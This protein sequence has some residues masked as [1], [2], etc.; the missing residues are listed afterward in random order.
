MS[1]S[2]SPLI[3]GDAKEWRDFPVEDFNEA[4]P[5]EDPLGELLAERTPENPFG[6]CIVANPIERIPDALVMRMSGTNIPT[7]IRR[8]SRDEQKPAKKKGKK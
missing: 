2:E 7:K 3:P 4:E 5:D 1:M 8:E 6:I